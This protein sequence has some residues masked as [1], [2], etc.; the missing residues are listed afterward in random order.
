MIKNTLEKL[1]PISIRV[2]KNLREDLV[3]YSQKNRRSL[4]SYC[5]IL[6][7]DNYSNFG[8]KHRYDKLLYKDEIFVPLSFTITETLKQKLINHIISFG[9]YH[10][11][12]VFFSDFIRKVL[13]D[14]SK[15]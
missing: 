2:P 11:N 13:S 14:S 7:E 9:R 6:I 8:K 5:R 4:S 1:K 10:Y 12:R 3:K 15:E